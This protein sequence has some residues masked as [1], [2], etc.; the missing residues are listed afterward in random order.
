MISRREFL[1]ATAA[2]SAVAG[3]GLVG[4]W[5]RAAAQQTLTEDALLDFE[6]FGNVTLVHLTDIHAQLRP[7]YF[8]EP[9]E[10]I[11]V[12]AVEGLPPHVTGA[13]FLKL[14]DIAP[15]S[16]HAYALTSEDFAALAGTYGR[17]G[18]LDRIA[19]IVK[20]I[21]AER[22]DSMLLLDGGDTWQ[23][24]YTSL[25]T[26]G[27]DMVEAM[28]ALAPDA[29][30]GHWE[31]TYGAERVSEIIEA[32]PFPFLGGNIYDAEWN[33]PAFE[34]YRMFERGGA[35][36]AVIGQAF[37]YTPIANPRWMFP[38]W[39]FGIREEDVI[40]N[41]GTARAEGAD[42]VVLLSHN[43]FDVDR[44]LASRVEGIDVIL[45]GHT[46]DALPEPVKVGS[47]LLIASGSHGKFV[48][49]LDLDVR[50]G[51]LKGFRHRLIPVFADVISPDPEM[52]ALI[53]RLREPYEA[54]LARK[55]ATTETLLYRR[56]NF[57]GSFDDLICQALIDVREADIALS[58]GFRW[59]TSLLPGDTITV[60]DLHNA[61]AMTYAA[62]YRSTMSGEMLH[63]ILEDVADN[64][65]NKDPYYQQ[66]GDMVRV[67]GMA[68]T[69]D[70]EQE[71]G[72]RISGMTLLKTGEPIEPA[73]DYVVAGWA[74]VNE[75]TEGPP[76]WEI[77]EQYLANN[78]VVRLEHNRHVTVA[79]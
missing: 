76:I 77:V 13:D 21:R 2:L 38:N 16:P 5:S 68:Y 10:N 28:N 57:N 58:P 69:I 14:Y 4:R 64:L 35:R 18:G 1:M 53:T 47:T 43:G 50:D 15:G 40:A 56:G 11:G 33:E 12:G 61:C 24:S 59:G 71:I 30:T 48:T 63:A 17:M 37:P 42:L 27:Q 49:R 41:V 44:A 65:F 62:A 60:E 78:P 9:S 45:T 75:A 52:D 26:N 67:G 7:V 51:T 46:H 74:S 66:G 25:K 20:R 36:I 70:P 6:S 8:R 54:E 23:G 31:F 22:G 73:R 32:L 19:T 72:S 39:S 34:A 3:P 79:N 29:M 55:L